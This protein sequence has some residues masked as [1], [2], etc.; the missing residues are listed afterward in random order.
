MATISL[1]TSPPPLLW[2]PSSSSQFN[3]GRIFFRI[4]NFASVSASA[5]PSNP[6]VV[7][8]RERGKN[9]K[10]VAAL[11]ILSY[12]LPIAWINTWSVKN[13]PLCWSFCAKNMVFS[14]TLRVKCDLLVDF[15][16]VWNVIGLF[17]FGEYYC[18]TM[19]NCLLK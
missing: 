16:V 4:R 14:L 1:S 9:G 11:V 10:L 3:K 6:K 19:L 18:F 17:C 5:H 7:V 8:T 12:S 2:S 13:F 15:C